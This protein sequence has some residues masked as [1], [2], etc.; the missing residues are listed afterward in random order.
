MKAKLVLVGFLLTILSSGCGAGDNEKAASPKETK[1]QT[2]SNQGFVI[3]ENPDARQVD[4]EYDGKPFT[5]YCYWENLKKPVFYPLHADDGRVVT[6][7]YPA[8][9]VPG[10]PVDHPHHLS[11]WFNYGDVNGDDYWGHSPASR[12]GGKYGTIV[13]RKVGDIHSYGDSAYV[14][15]QMDWIGS[16]GDKVL[17]ETDRVYFHAGPG[18]R[19]I[20]RLITL[21]ALDKKVVFGDTKEGMFAIRVTHELEEPTNQPGKYVDAHGNVTEV[22]PRD[23]TGVD[24]EYLSSEGRV[25]EKEVWGTRAKWCILRGTVQGKPATIGIF[26]HPDNVGYP[27]Y[28]H[29]RGYGLFA[30]NPLGWKTFTNGEKELNFTLAPGENTTIRYRILIASRRLEAESTEKL[31]ENWLKDIGR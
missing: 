20:D 2:M 29:A 16:Q 15:F 8:K 31:Y 18:L 12:P 17:E 27:T 25:N 7:S 19:I 24:G 14:D 1:E 4:I 9:L 11:C 6:R 28:W 10:E 22:A 26:D 21:T 23:N 3:S 30:A 5:S 13:H